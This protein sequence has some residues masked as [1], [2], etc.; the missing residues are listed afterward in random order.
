MPVDGEQLWRPGG[1]RERKAVARAAPS[2]PLL[3]RARVG[4]TF[5]LVVF[6]M[7]VSGGPGLLFNIAVEA[8]ALLLIAVLIVQGPARTVSLP[9]RILIGVIVAIP[10]LQLVPLPASLWTELPGRE[11]IVA[12]YRAASLPSLA[13]P[14]SL[15]PDATRR[16]ALALL[17]GLALFFSAARAPTRERV[18]LAATVLALASLSAVLGVFQFAAG[19]GY[20]YDT[21]HAGWATGLFNN[22][23]QNA[24]LILSGI[25]LAAGLGR[26]KLP[27]ARRLLVAAA[28]P[29][30]ALCCLAT[31]S[32]MGIAMLPFVLAASLALL[33]VGGGSGGRAWPWLLAGAGAAVLASAVPFVPALQPVFA[34]FSGGASRDSRFGYWANITAATRRYL[35]VGSGVGT[36]VPVYATVEDL[37]S[38]VVEYV[39]HAHNE[40]LEIALETGVVGLLAVLGYLVLLARASFSVLGTRDWP[41]RCASLVIVLVML[42]HSAIEYPLRNFILLIVWALGNAWVMT[43]PVDATDGRGEKSRRAYLD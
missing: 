4:L 24:D 23:N 9:L 37:D 18:A 1:G 36:F 22:R 43:A 7:L 20:L 13:H 15:D 40:Y 32:R 12:I 5:T 39:N 16:S 10:L 19:T 31:G 38:V 30:L 11:L 25:A 34:R 35:P 29:V 27:R 33:F 2:R 21:A 41:L 3:D 6:G 8:L 17:P 28:M 42:A 26:W 14:L